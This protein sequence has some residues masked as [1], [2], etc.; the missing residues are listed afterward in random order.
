MAHSSSAHALA[1]LAGAVFAVGATTLPGWPQPSM[2]FVVAA[3]A[4]LAVALLLGRRWPVVALLATALLGVCLCEWRLY[5]YQSA[6]ITELDGERVLAAVAFDSLPR[7]RGADSSFTARIT[8]LRGGARAPQTGGSRQLR[9]RIDWHDAPDLRPGECWQLL[10]T[11][12]PPVRRANPGRRSS[13]WQWLRDGL[14]GTAR[15]LPSRLNQRLQRAPPSV[16]ALRAAI[17]ARLRDGIAERDAAAL[18]VA[19][20]VGDTQ[21]LSAE[22]WRVFNATGITHL[23]AISGLHVTMFALLAA[24]LARRLWRRCRPLQRWRRESVAGALA[25]LAAGGYAALAG[26]GIPAQRTLIMLVAWYALRALDRPPAAAPALGVALL[27]IL[28]FD[29]LA[30]LS[31][32]FWLSFVAVALLIHATGE[33]G[34]WRGALRAQLIVT[35]G[36][37]PVSLALVGSVS[38]IGLLLNFIAIPLFTLL[39]V[40]LVLLTS[41]LLWLPEL[42]QALLSLLAWLHALWWPAALWLAEQPDV[43]WR[44][45]PPLWWL[46]LCAPAL[47]WLLWP[48]AWPMRLSGCLLLLPM[49]FPAGAPLRDGEVMITLLDAGSAL[50][51]LV[52]TRDHALLYDNGEAWGS[53]GAT[54]IGT[55]LPA[56][57]SYR[58]RRLDRVLMPRLDADRSAG[59]LALRAGM[60]IDMLQAA[61]QVVGPD[62]PLPPEFSSCQPIR[63]QWNSV[64]IEILDT[65]DCALRIVAGDGTVLLLAADLA[66]SG[67]QRLMERGLA[68]ADIVLAPRRL[69]A[70]ADAALLQDANAATWILVSHS[71]RELAGA[72][73]QRALSAWRRQG[74]R[75]L[76]TAELGAIELRAGAGLRLRHYRSVPTKPY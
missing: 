54:S 2:R 62:A 14:H 57:R 71:A 22:Q 27:A 66:P 60:V 7:R 44:W 39:L 43:L 3:L 61:P 26:F 70:A 24:A 68:R 20:A 36:L 17:S 32:G 12:Y 16:D 31:A 46:L 23:I 30:P 25:C 49:L 21:Y 69:A 56:L 38:L 45:Q 73:A 8:V 15:V 5:R 76:P 33:S 35:A 4:L 52:R 40:P 55:V 65:G 75:L 9:V 59:L 74:A 6:L 63:W 51:L 42:A 11:L 37:L 13:D 34:G 50:A 18:A 64:D 10:M 72:G 1:L 28:L 19:L 48:W 53:N 47:L 67:Q 58:I 29:P 41:A